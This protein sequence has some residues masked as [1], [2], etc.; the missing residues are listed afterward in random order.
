MKSSLKRQNERL[1]ALYAIALDL[2]NHHEVEDVLNTIILRASELLESPVGFLDLLDGE[3]LVIQATTEAVKSS[4]G[5]RV[6]LKSAHLTDLAIQTRQPQFVEDYI[7][8]PDRVKLHDPFQMQAACTFPIVIND[9]AVGALSLGR[10]EPNKPFTDED[11]D[12]MRS[13]A[14]LAALAIESAHLFEETR[15]RSVTDGLTELANRRQFDDLL[16]QEWKHALRDRKPLA[17]IMVDVDSFKK[18]NDTYGHAHGD[19]CLKQIAQ[20]LVKGGR[21]QYD[22]SARYGG[23]EFALILPNINLANARRRAEHLRKK[24]EALQIPHPSSE[25]SSWIT[26]SLGVAALVPSSASDPAVLLKLADQ[27]LYKAKRTGRNRVCSSREP[28]SKH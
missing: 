15:K 1:T 23:E 8:R 10:T 12:T 25:T 11:V 5:E 18:Y 14:Q 2:L 26:I 9:K 27:A 16:A 6:P 13:L 28:N 22:I 4:K 24:V 17:L 3:T 20:A 7:K 21:R 19:E